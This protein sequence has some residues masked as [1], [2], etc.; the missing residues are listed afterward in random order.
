MEFTFFDIIAMLNQ[1]LP[2]SDNFAFR[3]ARNAQQPGRYLLTRQVLPRENRPDWHVTGGTMTITPTLLGDVAMDS[4]YPPMG[5]M[6]ATAFFEN[7]SKFAGQMFFNEK[8]QRELITAIN[9]LRVAGSLDGLSQAQIMGDFDTQMNMIRATGRADDNTINGRRLNQVLGILASIQKSNWDTGEYLAGMALTEGALSYTFNDIEMNVS[10]DIP[11]ANVK[12]YSGNDRFDQSASKFWTFIKAAYRQ[13]SNP[14]FI[15]NSNSYYDVA[16]NTVNQ[17]EGV[18]IAGDTRRL[19]RYQENVI[20]QR[21]DDRESITTRIYDA[22]GAVMNPAT[23][24]IVSKP[25]IKDKR[26]IAIGGLNP[27]GIEL[28]LGGMTDPDNSLRLGYTHVGPTVEGQG[29][30]GIWARI[31]TPEGKP[32]QVLAETAVNMLPAILNPK[33]IMIAKWD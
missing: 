1:N 25:F 2:Q 19:V 6:E 18:Q 10:Y 29:R 12:D 20:R 3:M 31:Y 15:W 22:A 23:K 8:Q 9:G 7:T 14:V 4:P 30:P 27:D 32:M 26:L 21:Q 13:L 33:R 11:A 24:S 5:N 28:T 17:I 16:E